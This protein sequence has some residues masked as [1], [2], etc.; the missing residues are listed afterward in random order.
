MKYILIGPLGQN[1]TIFR[2]ASICR[3]YPAK[4]NYFSKVT[5]FKKKNQLQFDPV[6]RKIQNQKSDPKSAQIPYF[7]FQ[8]FGLSEF[9]I[10]GQLTYS[11]LNN[12]LVNNRCCDVF[13]NCRLEEGRAA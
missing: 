4:G 11:F 2:C 12:G 10:F 5:K 3:T 13:C 7:D 6:G 9:W 8:T 1:P